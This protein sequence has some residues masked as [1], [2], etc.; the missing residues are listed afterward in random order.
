[1]NLRKNL[2]LAGLVL[3]VGAVLASSI[4]LP[5]SPQVEEKPPNPCEERILEAITEV[6]EAAA[7]GEIP[8]EYAEEQIMEEIKICAEE[9]GQELIMEEVEVEPGD[10]I[11][12]CHWSVSLPRII[13]HRVSYPWGS[14]LHRSATLQS[15]IQNPSRAA[16][17]KVWPFPVIQEGISFNMPPTSMVQ[18][19]MAWTR[20]PHTDLHIFIAGGT[21]RMDVCIAFDN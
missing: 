7:V 11:I 14:P 16:Q 12:C 15:E 5:T 21:G 2:K 10:G 13:T 19:I 17:I 18:S 20:M 9:T 8:M 4:S 1:M 3:V 6:I